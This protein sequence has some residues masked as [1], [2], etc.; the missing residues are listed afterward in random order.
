VPEP[1]PVGEVKKEAEKS[2]SGTK[3]PAK[4]GETVL[5][6]DQIRSRRNDLIKS[7]RGSLNLRWKESS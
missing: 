4:P 6:R 3:D 5:I 2:T 7:T 1:V